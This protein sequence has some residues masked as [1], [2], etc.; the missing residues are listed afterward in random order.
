VAL[1]LGFMLV[2]LHCNHTVNFIVVKEVDDGEYGYT[3]VRCPSSLCG[4]EDTTA[5]R[6]RR[7]NANPS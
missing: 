6:P 4:K 5:L 7:E 1:R 3:V 2:C